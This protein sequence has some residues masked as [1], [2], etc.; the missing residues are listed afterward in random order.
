M[1]TDRR[2]RGY[3]GALLLVCLIISGVLI[4]QAIR[5]S[6]GDI[7]TLF[8]WQQTRWRL[9]LLAIGIWLLVF[10][11]LTYGSSIYLSKKYTVQFRL[12][13]DW[14]VPLTVAGLIVGFIVAYGWL[15]VTRHQ[16]FNST[17]YDLAINE[18]IVWNTV[19][20]RFFASS[21]EVDNSFADHFRP[22]LL[23]LVP[24]YALFPSPITLLILQTIG[25]GLGAVPVYLLAKEK[26]NGTWL[27]L[28]LTAVYLLYPATGYI[29]RFDFH[30]EA[31]AIPAFL[32]AF[33]ALE[34]KRWGWATFW[35]IIPLLCKE[36]MGLSVAAFG[37]YALLI[38]KAYRWGLVWFITG[39]TV[40]GTTSFWLIP[41]VRGEAS[42]TLS[43]YDWLGSTPSAMIGNVLINPRLVLTEIT[44][45]NRLFYMS[46]LLIPTGLLALIG[47]PE[48]LIGLPGLALNLLAQH[49]CQPTIYCQYTVPV[50]P[51]IFVATIF[52]LHRLNMIIQPQTHW[53]LWG[54]LLLPLAL[55][56]LWVDNPFREMEALPDALAHLPNAD[57]VQMALTTI[58]DNTVVVTTNDYASHLAR[59]TELYVIGIPS[60]RE[61]PL[62]PDI[63]FI[64]LYDQEYIVCDQYREYISKLDINRFGVTLRTGGIIV[65]Q[66]DS[67]DNTLFRDFIMNWNNCAG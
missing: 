17:G 34:R 3:F 15:S 52:G 24:F 18:Q 2:H 28:V 50:T 33:Y 54:A 57:V 66:K 5:L 61:A 36:N 22:F 26:L 7:G 53:R 63:V 62:D 46:Q 64:N 30:V 29:A 27:P 59:R 8:P 55:F 20:G 14:L 67:G 41:T 35:L 10:S 12:S 21:I 45:P 23:A 16:R 31:F 42:D 40:F 11:V 37:L 49:H 6:L 13:P 38:K 44:Q 19:H 1:I 58:P 48:L 9:L 43:R 25:L 65:I 4:W 60:Q 32:W 39:L 47:L 51:F 56:A